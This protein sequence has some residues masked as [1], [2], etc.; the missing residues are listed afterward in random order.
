[1][2]FQPASIQR[3]S[4]DEMMNYN[5]IL[6]LFVAAV[7]ATTLLLVSYLVFI[8]PLLQKTKIQ[9]A[10]LEDG[11][12]HNINHQQLL[13]HEE[14]SMIP[15]F[16]KQSRLLTLS[17]KRK[18]NSPPH[19]PPPRPPTPSTSPP[20]TLPY[21]SPLIN[22]SVAAVAE[23][24]CMLDHCLELL[25]SDDSSRWNECSQSASIISSQLTKKNRTANSCRFIDEPNRDAVALV[26]FPG[27]G[28]TWVRGILEAVT[29]MCTGAVYCDFSLR[30]N[31]FAGEATRGGQALV[32]KTHS[33]FSE[34]KGGSEIEIRNL[35]ALK[36]SFGAAI[37][38][39]RNPFDALVAEWNR[40]I[41]N[42][43][44]T[45]TMVID[46]HTKAFGPEW[47]GKCPVPHMMSL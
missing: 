24:H 7:A 47:F 14:R 41:A 45:R 39:V 17:Q 33:D 10:D 37:L 8:P 1:M 26:S 30:V 25:N 3:Y 15:K 18:F 22:I 28:N 13:L 42:K 36:G 11:L 2:I 34:W 40:K 27:S 38:I 31:G 19:S 20:I 32:V 21:V 16:S 12:P 44:E 29:G 9:L 43:F 23:Q 46:S 5:L 6:N 35:R 4:N